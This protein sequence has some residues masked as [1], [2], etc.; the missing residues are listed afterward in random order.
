MDQKWSLVSPTRAHSLTAKFV[1][2]GGQ[3]MS[4]CIK[5]AGMNTHM[6]ELGL[7]AMKVFQI[8]TSLLAWWD[9]FEVAADGVGGFCRLVPLWVF[10]RWNKA[11]NCNNPLLFHTVHYY[12][13]LTPSSKNEYVCLKH[14]SHVRF[15]SFWKKLERV[16]CVQMKNGLTPSNSGLLVSSSQCQTKLTLAA[17]IFHYVNETDSTWKLMPIWAL[18]LLISISVLSQLLQF[19][20]QAL[21]AMLFTYYIYFFCVWV[22]R[23]VFKPFTL[24]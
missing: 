13:Y 8:C 20:C 24:I 2:P 6:I 14:Q 15:V 23:S 7:G 1:S 4:Q 22:N 12:C 5:A 17:V 21:C 16:I 18:A 3:P 19:S 9:S 11:F 10:W